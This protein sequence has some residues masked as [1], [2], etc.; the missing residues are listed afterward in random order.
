VPGDSKPGQVQAA[1][2]RAARVP[3]VFAQL[4]K[5]AGREGELPGGTR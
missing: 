1:V 4:V 2:Q 5:H 3:A